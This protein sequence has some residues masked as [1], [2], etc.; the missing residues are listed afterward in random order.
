M[1][2]HGNRSVDVVVIG[3]G[4]YGL[5]LAAHLSSQNVRFRIFGKPM[6]TWAMQMPKGMRLKSEG[7][8]SSL[9]DP[10]RRFTL[11]HY[12]KERGIPYADF[13]LPVP[14][15]TFVSYGL[16]F[17]RRFVPE[18]EDKKVVAV[19]RTSAGFEVNLEGGES[20]ACSKVVVATGIAHF[21]HIPPE[22][23]GLSERLLTHSSQHSSLD[24]FKDRDVLVVGA[25][26]SALD[27]AAL[28]HEAGARVQLVARSQKI[29]FHDPPRPRS[30]VDSLRAPMTELGAGWKLFFYTN[31]PLLFHRLSERLRLKIMQK[32]LGPA[33][34]WFVKEQAVGKFP[35]YLGVKI[36]SA[37]A[38]SSRI[39][40]GLA[41]GANSNA[42]TVEGDHVIAATGY[43]VNLER[44]TFLHRDLLNTIECVEGS[45]ILSRNFESSI[46]GLY[47]VGTAAANSFG[48]MMRF[49][50]GAD[51]T[52]KRVS[53]HLGRTVR[54]TQVWVDRAQR[55]SRL[56]GQLKKTES[57]PE[58]VN[59]TSTI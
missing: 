44:L 36:V 9:S 40:L 29:R 54:N 13:G 42:R 14:L 12:C 22:L 50:C 46:P 31:T 10:G 33:P 4:P 57:L 25:G 58:P 11:A 56:K 28:L 59:S 16:E 17:Q 52:A 3:A 26:A 41:D 18:L 30:L 5:S 39:V 21:G 45:P 2:D 38:R 7:F 20:V 43:R 49:A 51:F 47:F 24:H 35:F 27:V 55:D 19:S 48:P 6:Q 34:G 8:A 1:K 53:H 32:T 37:A 15:E 23:S